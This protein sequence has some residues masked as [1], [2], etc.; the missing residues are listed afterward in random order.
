MFLSELAAVAQRPHQRDAGATKK[1]SSLKVK[2]PVSRLLTRYF[3]FSAIPLAG[4]LLF[5]DG[6]HI[7]Q[8]LDDARHDL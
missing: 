4:V 6:R 5:I 1:Y 2:K 8:G 7:P 3:G